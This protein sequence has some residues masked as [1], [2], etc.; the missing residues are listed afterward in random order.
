MSRTALPFRAQPR[1]PLTGRQFNVSARTQRELDA[2]LHELDTMR[3]ELRLAMMRA[4]PEERVRIAEDIDRRVRTMTRGR[5]TLEQAARDYADRGGLAPSTRKSVLSSWLGGPGKPLGP[6][7]LEALDAPT[8]ER[9]IDALR[10]GGYAGSSI[11]K[12]WRT[13]RAVIRYATASGW[14]GQPPWG[15]WRP[16]LRG[17]RAPQAEREAARTPEELARLLAGA[18]E[19]DELARQRSRR[20]LGDLE[21]RIAAVALLGLRQGELAGLRWKDIDAAA[22]AVT[23]ARQ[24]G[25]KH[26]RLPKGGAVHTLATLPELLELL[27]RVRDRQLELGL[28]RSAASDGPVFPC[29]SAALERS[30]AAHHSPDGKPIPLPLEQLRAAVRRAGL[31]RPARWT[32]TSLRDTF[33]TLEAET[34]GGDL[35]RLADRTRHASIGSLLHYLRTR[36]RRPLA[37]GFALPPAP[38]RLRALPSAAPASITTPAS[39]PPTASRKA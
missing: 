5:M 20:A 36:S 24:W 35:K 8:L 19:L 9:W 32:A 38:P 33:A 16:L 29:P 4:T 34:Y 23:I 1:H 18:A 31:P 25:G 30:A 37:P 26:A 39:R 7:P 13:L 14:I 12:A 6:L 27:E 22:G 15:V 21:A 28:L 3:A 17:A 11:G 10:G 2:T